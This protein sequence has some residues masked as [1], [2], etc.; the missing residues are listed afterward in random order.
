MSDA[1]VSPVPART[2]F[3]LYRQALAWLVLPMYNG[4]DRGNL[5]RRRAVPCS[6]TPCFRL[7]QE[8]EL[9]NTVDCRRKCSRI[10]NKCVGNKG[11]RRVSTAQDLSKIFKENAVVE[12][13]GIQHF[14]CILRN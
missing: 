1:R 8:W 4:G 9:K 11:I 7:R 10:E 3:R 13:R 14:G 5:R 6:F 12:A 2:S